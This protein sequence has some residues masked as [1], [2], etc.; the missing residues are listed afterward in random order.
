[1]A[2][3]FRIVHL[4]W[5][6]LTLVDLVWPHACM[7]ANEHKYILAQGTKEV[8]QEN[9]NYVS[10][11]FK[12]INNS[13]IIPQHQLQQPNVCEP[14]ECAVYKSMKWRKKHKH[15]I[16]MCVYGMRKRL[17]SCYLENWSAFRVCTQR[18]DPDNT[19]S[20][21][22]RTPCV[23]ARA[24]WKITKSTEMIDI[25]VHLVCFMLLLCLIVTFWG[26]FSISDFS[27]QFSHFSLPFALHFIFDS[28]FGSILLFGM[29]EWYFIFCIA[30]CSIREY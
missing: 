25:I 30:I 13:T 4:N 2:I 17:I 26:R 24:Q 11:I 23:R 19:N 27:F 28:W 7:H 9:E 21:P 1:M 5:I 16:H 22:A 8:K 20:K 12:W 10:K 6:E 14:I 29:V 3:I 15:T 18:T